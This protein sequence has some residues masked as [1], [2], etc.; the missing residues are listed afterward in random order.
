MGTE[1]TPSGTAEAR[2]KN[3]L[4]GEIHSLRSD[5][6]SFFSPRATPQDEESLRY[7]FMMEP[8]KRAY[9]VSTYVEQFSKA[10]LNDCECVVQTPPHSLTNGEA[11]KKVKNIVVTADY[12]ITNM[13]HLDPSYDQQ[14]AVDI[15]T[16]IRRLTEEV[17]RYIGH[18]LCRQPFAPDIN[19]ILQKP[20]TMPPEEHREQYV[21]GDIAYT[22]YREFVAL[23]HQLSSGEQNQNTL[24]K[25][26]SN[27]QR[28]INRMEHESKAETHITAIRQTLDM[29]LAQEPQ[30]DR[31]RKVLIQMEAF[32]EE[33]A[34]LIS[35]IL[36]EMYTVES[37]LMSR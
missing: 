9:S 6:N 33:R 5:I 2:E 24:Q 13:L 28:L 11:I 10:L 17:V 4:S 8:Y 15:A 32:R 27:V 26:L 22:A 29:Q 36:D 30:L 7:Q 35:R 21:L 23:K 18:T 16:H 12:A 25:M 14:T 20:L 37:D 1:R 31:R 3:R 34:M 19:T